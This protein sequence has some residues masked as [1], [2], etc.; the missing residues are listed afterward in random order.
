MVGTQISVEEYLQT[1]YRPDCDYVDGE[2]LERNV[3]EESHGRFQ[4]RIAAFF[5]SRE[6]EW[7]VFVIIEQRAQVSPTRF[8]VPDVCIYLEE[9]QEEVFHTPPFICAEVLSPEDR[10]GLVQERID[11]YLKFGVPYVWVVDPL[12]H[13]AWVHTK[14][15]IREVKDGVLRAENPAL[16]V[17]LTELFAAIGAK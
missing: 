15:E 4:L 2:V 12:A 1:V 8:R 10:I 16:A 11:D 17:P 5:L 6:E 14:D 7:N 3:G 13:R 9:P